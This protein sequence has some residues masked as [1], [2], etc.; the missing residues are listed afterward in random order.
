MYKE[1]PSVEEF[2]EIIGGDHISVIYVTCDNCGP[3]EEMT[4]IFKDI[5]KEHEDIPFL[6]V[7][8]DHD[9]HFALR[10][11]TRVIPAFYLVER[12]KKIRGVSTTYE[13]VLRSDILRTLSPLIF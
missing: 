7:N 10:F 13:S 1:F 3:K 11:K 2:E 12:G 8:V 9:N 6:K 4:P 5:A